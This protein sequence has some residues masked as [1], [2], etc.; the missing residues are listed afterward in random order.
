ML[1]S[2]GHTG[3]DRTRPLVDGR[4][5][6]PG[7][8]LDDRMSRPATL[9]RD[10]VDGV[11]YDVTEMSLSGY[12]R[13]STGALR[14]YIALPVFPLRA[15]RHRDIYIAAHS[16]I[17]SP[18]DLRGRRIGFFNPGMTAVV[19]QR[20]ILSE[21]FG[22]GPTDAR[23]INLEGETGRR[24]VQQSG[25]NGLPDLEEQTL[26]LAADLLGKGHLDAILGVSAPV[27][28]D[29][30]PSVHA[31][32][33]FPEYEEVERAYYRS[34]GLWPIM[35]VVICDRELL[36]GDRN[37]AAIL[38]KAFVRARN[39][40]VR[41]LFD[42]DAHPIIYPWAEAHFSEAL[43]FFGVDNFWSY[44]LSSNADCLRT[45]I[46]YAQQQGL[47]DPDFCMDNVILDETHWES[48]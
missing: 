9:F 22:V 10:V 28:A 43:A 20:G 44:G 31:R 29:G 5:P 35:H 42:S 19:W 45:F 18:E 25:S 40:A 48:R 8:E 17:R 26:R 37:L 36:S 12:L 23:W 16:P 47:L 13:H 33:L 15:F 24:A 32:R 39:T 1:L 41:D 38:Y 7:I 14:N 27:D 30:T 2:F 46:T 11:R 3:N 6:L 4:V 34:T 21:Q